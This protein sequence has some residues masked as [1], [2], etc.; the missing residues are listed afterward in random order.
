MNDIKK[1]F[2]GILILAAT[3]SGGNLATAQSEP[4]DFKEA[5]LGQFTYTTNRLVSLAEA[6]PADSYTWSP[7]GEAMPVAQVYMHI[8]R[9]NFL[10]PQSSLGI[11]VPED[12]D[13]D[14]MEEL[15]DKEVVIEHLKQSVEHIKEHIGAMTASELQAETELYGRTVPG[16]QVLFQLQTHMSE[17]TGQSIAYARMNEI[18]PPWSR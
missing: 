4:G 3:L 7:D 16:W 5:F 18:T 13:L 14:D 9:Y 10:Y 2:T 15:A 8:A 1:I 11:E 12:I 6:M 17:H